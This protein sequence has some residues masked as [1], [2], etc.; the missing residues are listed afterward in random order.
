MIVHFSFLFTIVKLSSVG[1]T[2][3]SL[4]LARTRLSAPAARL[5][6]RGFGQMPLHLP[7]FQYLP[8][9]FNYL[10]DLHPLTQI[11]PVC[12]CPYTCQSRFLFS[13]PCRMPVLPRGRDSTCSCISVST[14]A[15][16]FIHPTWKSLEDKER[17]WRR[18]FL[19]GFHGR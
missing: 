15:T 9:L 11:S 18:F 5:S 13:P 12:T 6:F 3:S 16:L 8:F 2:I 19:R 4:L 17:N 10:G 14:G 7:A 1:P